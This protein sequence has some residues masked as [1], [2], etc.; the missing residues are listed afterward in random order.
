MEDEMKVL[1][2]DELEGVAGGAG[3]QGNLEICWKYIKSHGYKRKI[4]EIN[5]KEGTYA[6][7]EYVYRIIAES[8]LGIICPSCSAIVEFC[9]AL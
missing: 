2:E 4:K 9:I 3:D 8:D 1:N 6:A 7:C 5:E